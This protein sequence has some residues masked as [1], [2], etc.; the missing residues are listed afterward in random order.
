MLVGSTFAW[1]TDS[2][3]S[4]QNVIQSGNLDVELYYQV[5]GQ[6]DWTKVTPSTNVFKA[7][8][9]WEP[10]Y[11][12]VVKL[13]VVNEGSLALKYTL[14]VNVVDEVKSTNVNGTEFKLSDFIKYGIVDGDQDYTRETAVAAVDATATAL[15]EAYTSDSISLPAKNDTNSDEKI[16]TMVVYMPTTVG[17]DANHAKGAAVP[18]I[19]LGINLFATQATVESDSFDNQ[20]DKDAIYADHYVRSDADLSA[21]VA[22]AK[23]GDVIAL[24]EGT[25]NMPKNDD[26]YNGMRLPA[27][28]TFIGA[29]DG[30]KLTPVPN[31]SGAWEQGRIFADGYTF[32]NVTFTNTVSPN[33][34]GKFVGCTFEGYNGLRQGAYK[35]D[36]YFVNCVFNNADGW[37]FHTEYLYGADVYFE[38]CRFSGLVEFTDTIDETNNVYFEKCAFTGTNRTSSGKIFY[39]WKNNAVLTDCAGYDANLFAGCTANGQVAYVAAN[40]SAALSTALSTE[41][42]TVL[43][44][45]G[46]YGV[47]PKIAAGTTVIGVDG[48]V[49]ENASGDA[50]PKGLSGATIENV[51]VRGKN[52]VS[53][54]SVQNGDVLFKNC[55]IDAGFHIDSS[56]DG[57]KVVFEDCTFTGMAYIKFGGAA[58]YILNNCT[59][60]KISP[61]L[62]SPWGR[63][64]TIFYGDITLT[65]CELGRLLRAGASVN[66]TVDSCTQNGTPIVDDSIVYKYNGTNYNNPV[67]TIK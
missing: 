41:N 61:E 26:W 23:D 33:G 54:G 43:L 28:V 4:A 8:A 39:A 6:T 56:A 63:E 47:C 32:E 50:L 40:D 55:T 64:Y 62:T 65:N 2:V 45:A 14:G 24:Y 51:T 22:A 10:G 29:E 67:V 11:T 1:F 27:N 9:L 57:K 58:D 35:N 49:F 53:W 15:A 38:N 36:T 44:G 17:N 48:T 3:T 37:A 5:E 13:K 12:E 66:I 19:N 42:N 16:V 60:E 18:T 34:Y 20:Y 21:A 30:V 46:N 7:G 52:A 59:I 25:Y 31:G